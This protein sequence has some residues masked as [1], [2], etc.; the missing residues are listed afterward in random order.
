[1][2]IFDIQRGSYHDGPGI[3]TVVFLK[4]CNLSC[5][6]CQ[7]PESQA[8]KPQ[9][10]FYSELCGGCGKCV[11]SCSSD[12]LYLED[13]V[14]RYNE[15]KCRFCRKCVEACCYEARTFSGR[16]VPEHEILKEVLKDEQMYRISGGGLTLS[17][18]EPLLQ[19]SRCRLLLEAV[20]SRGIHTLI[21]TAGNVRWQCLEEVLPYT[22]SIFMDL[23][24]LDEKM[25]RIYCGCSNQTILENIRRLAKENVDLTVRT[26]VIPEVNDSEEDIRSM[27]GFLR[28]CGVKKYELLTFHTLGAN[29]YTALGERYVWKN[30]EMLTR[31][32]MESLRRAAW[33][34]G[35]YAYE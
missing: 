12:A 31:E 17:G 28:E 10:M 30:K 3:R 2:N 11:E 18:G 7:N 21:E 4:G 16:D 19:A 23:K 26:P 5:T 27:A 1:M 8:V 9:M 6:W 20:K 13:K 15:K 14:I 32:K 24:H 35:G 33:E 25:H 34:E 22:D 29:K